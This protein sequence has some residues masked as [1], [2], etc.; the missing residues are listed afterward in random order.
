MQYITKANRASFTFKL[1]NCDGSD[2]DLS[3]AT[4][5]FIVKK[6]RNQPDSLAI[7]T[8]EYIKPET[9]YLSFDFDSTLTKGLEI[10]EYI[11]ALKIYRDSHLDDEIWTEEIQVVKGVFDE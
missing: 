9:N 10:G 2:I 1:L 4:V 8:G 11:G 6:D 3:H 7:L 5:K